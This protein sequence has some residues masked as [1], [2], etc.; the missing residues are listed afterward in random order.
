MINVDD[1]AK[2][3]DETLHKREAEIPQAKAIIAAHIQDFIDWHEMR[4]NVPLLKAVKH[5]LQA[6]DSCDLYNHQLDNQSAKDVQMNAAEK[7]QKVIN[8]MATKMRSQNYRG[9]NYIEAINEYIATG[10][11]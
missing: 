8:G 7:I 3:K 4:K 6:M 10:T 9:C 1:L 2:I 11:N 5:K